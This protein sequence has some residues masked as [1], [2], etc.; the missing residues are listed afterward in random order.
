L[1]WQ[2]WLLAAALADWLIGRTLSRAA[3]FIPKSGIMVSVMQGIM[4]SGQIA[5]NLAAILTLAAIVWLAWRGLGRA[6][7]H[8][9][10][11]LALIGM[12]GLSVAGVFTPPGPAALLT[13]HALTLAALAIVVTSSLRARSDFRSR[14]ASAVPAFAIASITAFKIIQTTGQWAGARFAPAPTPEGVIG[15]FALG[16][17]EAGE[18]FVVLSP[19]AV[20]WAYG[21][22]G[23]LRPAQRGRA[24]DW[25][26]AA[27]PAALFAVAYVASPSMTATMATWSVGLSLYLPWPAYAIG[28]WLAG[29]TILRGLRDERPAGYGLAFL[30]AAGY[31]MQ[32]SS[33]VMLGLLGI[34]CLTRQAC[35]AYQPAPVGQHG[36][37]PAIV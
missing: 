23:C 15:P 35:P 16:A 1:R 14:L 7:R 29:V 13:F 34:W 12:V 36:A 4:T 33:Q 20:W 27:I 17:F 22:A 32:L 25:I 18:L 10:L 24:R 37:S 30:V 26:V 19:L 21:R 5:F 8:A 6:E 3:I 2:N 31:S 11:S 9:P 28:L